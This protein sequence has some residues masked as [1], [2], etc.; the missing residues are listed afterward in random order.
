MMC[1]VQQ[2]IP[3]LIWTYVV[4]LDSINGHLRLCQ[5]ITLPLIQSKLLHGVVHRSCPFPLRP[6]G[7]LWSAWWRVTQ[8][9][10][11]R[12]S[13]FFPCLQLWCSEENLRSQAN[14]LWRFVSLESKVKSSDLPSVDWPWATVLSYVCGHFWHAS[15]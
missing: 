3:C 7:S 9:F 14:V 8:G 1:Y 4:I 2:I 12:E 11:R 5:T 6:I 15:I 13:M 10:P